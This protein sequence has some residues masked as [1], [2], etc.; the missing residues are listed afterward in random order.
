MDID[1]SGSDAKLPDRFDARLSFADAR[2][3]GPSVT[4]ALHMLEGQR[5]IRSERALVVVRDR[6]GLEDYAGDAYGAPEREY[7][8]L[9]DIDQVKTMPRVGAVAPLI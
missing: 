3:R 2:R 8:R 5:L 6:S 1:V 7:H 4:I 9:M